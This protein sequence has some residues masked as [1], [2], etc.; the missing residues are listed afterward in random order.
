MEFKLGEYIE[1]GIG[2]SI[3]DKN[4]YCIYFLMDREGYTEYEVCS[5]F[6]DRGNVLHAKV[7]SDEFSINTAGNDKF[8]DYL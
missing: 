8:S 3:H 7:V 2:E 5:M 1:V 6:D 4:G